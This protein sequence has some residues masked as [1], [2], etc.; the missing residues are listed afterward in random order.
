[1]GYKSPFGHFQRLLLG[2]PDCAALGSLH[3]DGG[4]SQTG[5]DSLKPSKSPSLRLSSTHT[6]SGVHGWLGSAGA[7][8]HLIHYI[9]LRHVFPVAGP[10]E[11]ANPVT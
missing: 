3:L 8:A 11:I 7:K 5:G 9:Q 6:G 1:M 2:W 4:F 10:Q